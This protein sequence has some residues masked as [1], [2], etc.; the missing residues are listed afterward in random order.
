[1]IP[2]NYKNEAGLSVYTILGSIFGV[3]ILI[4]IVLKVYRTK[5]QHRAAS[6]VVF[7]KYTYEK[8]RKDEQKKVKEKAKSLVLSSSTKL[9]GFANEVERYG[10]YALAMNDL[11]I[12]SA[13]PDNPV[14]HEVKNPYTAILPGNYLIRAV[15][16]YLLSEHNISL[17][18]SE[19][20][21]YQAKNEIKNKDGA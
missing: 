20:K 21:N 6:N 5:Q 14:W 3:L 10:W 17:N 9:R 12:P 18:V 4:I 15:S 1:M 13:V 16:S 19:A 7:A 2:P 8:M 11:G